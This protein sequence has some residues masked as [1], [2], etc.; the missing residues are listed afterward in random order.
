[1]LGAIQE[2]TM[3]FT[4]RCLDNERSSPAGGAPGSTGYMLFVVLSLLALAT[5]STAS[6]GTVNVF[7]VK[8]YGAL[9]NG[10]TDDRIAIQSAQNAIVAAGSGTLYFPHGTYN[11]STPGISITVP[12]IIVGDGQRSS[13]VRTDASVSSSSVFSVSLNVS[14]AGAWLPV[15]FRD[16]ALSSVLQNGNTTGITYNAT[17]QWANGLRVEN[18]RFEGG[19]YFGMYIATASTF[20]IDKCFFQGSVGHDLLID[21]TIHADVGDGVI[22]NSTFFG[23]LDTFSAIFHIGGGGLKVLGNKF[24]GYHHHYYSDMSIGSA[25]QPTGILHFAN[26]SSE[27]AAVSNLQFYGTE[28]YEAIL[29]Q[30]NDF[31]LGVIDSQGWPGSCPQTTSAIKVSPIGAGRN[32]VGMINGNVFR[33][34]IAGSACTAITITP[35]ATAQ[36][37]DWH[38]ANNVFNFVPRAILIGAAAERV[39]V[40]E[41]KYS[42]VTTKIDNQS[43]SSGSMLTIPNNTFVPPSLSDGGV[44]FVQGGALKYRGANGTVTTLANP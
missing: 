10:F 28:H 20:V 18:V 42:F 33:G 15:V 19:L 25:P 21:N 16:L 23:N 7:N 44:L 31:S 30:N 4:I 34:Y 11:V 26:N 3:P 39:Q 24:I 13:T 38:I 6:A 29:I 12:T 22:T 43:P 37:P 35:S 40:G 5:G 9:G 1:M 2:V 27:F 36:T 17:P 14:Q 8:D 32:P 41:N